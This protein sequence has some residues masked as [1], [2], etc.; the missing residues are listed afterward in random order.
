MFLFVS[1]AVIIR[2]IVAM[3]EASALSRLSNIAVL[4]LLMALVSGICQAS[5]YGVSR[6]EVVRGLQ[7]APKMAAHQLS[8]Y[9][10]APLRRTGLLSHSVIDHDD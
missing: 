6:K 2:A 3:P 9:L 7:D 1:T 5:F 10:R 4:V 8:V